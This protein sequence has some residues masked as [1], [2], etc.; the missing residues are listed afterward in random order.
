MFQ[1]EIGDGL[2]LGSYAT[3]CSTFSYAPLFI[4]YLCTPIKLPHLFPSEFCITY[5]EDR[6]VFYF[7]FS[8]LE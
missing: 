8:Y 4:P 6:I 2:F 5:L 7:S 1:N 3:L